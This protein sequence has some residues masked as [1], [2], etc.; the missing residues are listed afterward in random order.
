L[1]A[2]FQT[3]RG[4]YRLSLIGEPER[5]GGDLVLTLAMERMDGIERFSFRCV[6]ASA[7]ADRGSGGADLDE[8]IERMAPWIERQF[9]QLREAALKSARSEGQLLEIRFAPAD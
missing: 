8:L 9:E 6:V 7:L 2:T 1:A 4:S 3:L 5:S